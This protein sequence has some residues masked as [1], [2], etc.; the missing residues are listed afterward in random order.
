MTLI[1]SQFSTHW[2]ICQYV[3]ILLLLISPGQHP[4]AKILAPRGRLERFVSSCSS[5][6]E[7]LGMPPASPLLLDI[8]ASSARYTH[9]E[10][11]TKT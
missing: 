7:S 6:A 8:Y 1:V 5:S 3:Y 10:G 11:I 2:D 9:N 4:W